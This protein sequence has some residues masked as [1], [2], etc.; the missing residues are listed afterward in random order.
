MSH[1]LI[2]RNQDLKRLRD[3][4]Y[5]IEINTSNLLVHDVPYVTEGGE[6][7]IGTLVSNLELNGDITQSPIQDHTVWFTGDFPCKKIGS[8]MTMLVV[9]T[10]SHELIPG[11]QVNHRFSTKPNPPGYLN[12]Y[13]KMTRYV[14]LLS[15]E[16]RAI[17]PRVTPM[18]FPLLIDAEEDGVF[19]YSDS[20]SS[21]AGISAISA[22]LSNHKIAIIGVGG[23]GAYILDLLAKTPVREIQIYDGDIFQQHNAFR[24]PGAASKEDLVSPKKK[25]H[26]YF[27]IYSRMRYG[28]VPHS[29]NINESNIDLLKT[30]DFVFLC[31]DGDQT[32][33][34]IIDYLELAGIPF[35]DCGIGV[36][37][38]EEKLAG[39]VRVTMCTSNKKDHI[40]KRVVCDDGGNNE[41]ASNIQIADLNA[42]NAV[43]AVIKWKKMCGFYND[44]DH[45]HHMTYTIDGN[46]IANEEE[47]N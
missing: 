6:I 31:I 1:R 9:E 35:I 12:Y 14:T 24:A 43:L 36:Y 22:K 2:S 3:E 4:G 47:L 34:A 30:V 37:T 26:Y 40:S 19:K 18:T 46:L 45:E 32:K 16:A 13:D 11:M 33:R 39:I 44:L 15:N 10:R 17:D 29:H 28:I 8:K 5:N 27:E 38:V 25:V 23:T 7:K 42:L 20:A 41:Y 21:R